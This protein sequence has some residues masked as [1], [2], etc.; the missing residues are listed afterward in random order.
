M[1]TP[2]LQLEAVSKPR[3]HNEGTYRCAELLRRAI[4]THDALPA[5]LATPTTFWPDVVR[6]P[7]DAYGYGDARPPRFS[8]TPRDVSNLLPVLA[9][10]TW[11][12]NQNLGQ[13]D[14]KI[15]VARARKTPWWKLAQM[16]GRSERTV[17][18]WHD[19]GI[20]AIYGRFEEETWGL[21]LAS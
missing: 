16:F 3:D 12:Q 9:W 7:E 6:N 10:I 4:R 15:I 19:G 18:R 8:P 21:E 20:A 11:L 17:Q 13:R 5:T 14:V 1:L 2:S